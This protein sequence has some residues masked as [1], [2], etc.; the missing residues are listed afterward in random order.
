MDWERSLQHMVEEN[1]K[2]LRE[3]LL[4]EEEKVVSKLLR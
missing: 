2:M 1:C 3:E 4:E